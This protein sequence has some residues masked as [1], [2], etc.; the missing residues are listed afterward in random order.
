MTCGCVAIARFTWPGRAESFICGGH[1][2]RLA[3][4]AAVMGLPLQIIPLSPSEMNNHT[5]EQDV[6]R[7]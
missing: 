5:C 7:D 2:P 4:V 1:E 3:A 6:Q